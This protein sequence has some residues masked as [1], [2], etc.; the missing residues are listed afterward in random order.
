MT[1]PRRQAVAKFTLFPG[2]RE[3]YWSAWSAKPDNRESRELG[4]PFPG[5]E[6][7]HTDLAHQSLE[8][9]RNAPILEKRKRRI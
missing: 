6:P 3:H 4:E 5:D 9:T 8:P 2:A 7:Q 1:S